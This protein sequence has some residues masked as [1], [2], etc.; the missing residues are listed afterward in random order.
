MKI[1]VIHGVNC[2]GGMEIGILQLAELLHESYDTW[3]AVNQRSFW[4]DADANKLDK[5]ITRTPVRLVDWDDVEQELADT[6]IIIVGQWH[7]MREDISVEALMNVPLKFELSGVKAEMVPRHQEYQPDFFITTTGSVTQA[8]SRH[9]NLPINRFITIPGV[10]VPLPKLGEPHAHDGIYFLNVCRHAPLKDLATLVRAF[11]DIPGAE[12]RLIMVGDGP[13]SESVQ[14]LASDDSRIKFA[15]F[16]DSPDKLDAIYRRADCFVQTSLWEGSSRS[17]KEAMAYGL[18]IIATRTGGTPEIIRHLRDA[19]LFKVGDATE[20]TYWMGNMIGDALLRDKLGAAARR[21]IEDLNA[22]ARSILLNI[23]GRGSCGEDILGNGRIAIT[24]I[25]PAHNCAQ[26]IDESV[27]S[28]LSQKD[29]PPFELVIVDD[30]STD[31]T[32]GVARE[33]AVADG[34]VRIISTRHLGVVAARNLAAETARGFALLPVDADDRL[35]DGAMVAMWKAFSNNKFQKVIYGNVEMFGGDHEPVL[36][37]LHEYD[38]ENILRHASIPVTVMHSKAMWAQIGGWDEAFEDGME[39]WEYNIRLGIAGHCGINIGIT[40]LQ[41]RQRQ[42]AR[43]KTM[44]RSEIVKRIRE[45]HARV[46]Q[47]E[48]SAMCCGGRRPGGPPPARGTDTLSPPAPLTPD[49]IVTVKY[50]GSRS[51]GFGVLG[52]VSGRRYRIPGSGGTFA[53]ASVDVRFF[54]SFNRGRDFV[55]VTTE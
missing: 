52:R 19:I 50:T 38:F 51:G 26:F 31:N 42:D 18:P 23:V 6:D 48:R 37:D 41:W 2:I 29:A 8:Q 40:T 39:D 43:S 9:R 5:R 49:Q 55:E 25:M 17:L 14:E 46:Y 22:S 34:R 35:S 27:M 44:D 54:K 28:V 45:K 30:G 16:V 47:G 15:G 11:K 32:L 12:H 21:R 10:P 1:G 13:T 33:I 36:R 7:F 53:V 24:V 4:S 3:F 20:L